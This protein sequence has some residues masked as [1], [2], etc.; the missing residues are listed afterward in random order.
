MFIFLHL[1]KMLQSALNVDEPFVIL[2]DIFISFFVPSAHSTG[3][4]LKCCIMIYLLLSV[5]ESLYSLQQMR[6]VLKKEHV[7]D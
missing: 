6:A 7:D 1:K 5:I 2:S 4:V 3:S